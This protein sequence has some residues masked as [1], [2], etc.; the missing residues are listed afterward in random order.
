[1]DFPIGAAKCGNTVDIVYNSNAEKSGALFTRYSHNICMYEDASYWLVKLFKILV[2]SSAQR[3]Q[4]EQ[5]SHLQPKQYY[6]LLYT[7][8]NHPT[9]HTRSPPRSDNTIRAENSAQCLSGI[10][11]YFREKDRPFYFRHRH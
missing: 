10:T 3:I 6:V 4:T 1:M 8:G 5:A 2:A 7:G 9:L 11:E